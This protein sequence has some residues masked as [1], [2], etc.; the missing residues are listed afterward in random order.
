[1]TR[2]TVI[3]VLL[4]KVGR[5]AERHP[6]LASWGRRK[7]PLAELTRGLLQWSFNHASFPLSLEGSR[8][9]T[10]AGILASPKLVELQLRDSAGL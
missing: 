5:Q 10:S 6:N 8:S 2:G 7:K 3:V 9:A 4:R 1:M